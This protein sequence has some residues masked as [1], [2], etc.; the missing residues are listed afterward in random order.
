[1]SLLP[2]VTRLSFAALLT[3]APLQP[4]ALAAWVNDPDGH[5]NLTLP[6]AAGDAQLVVPK[7][8]RA[9]PCS[10]VIVSHGR[11]GLASAG[12]QHAP[13]DTL[14]DAIDTQGFV[15]LLSSDGGPS[16][17]GNTAALSSIQRSYKAALPHF[18][19]D[20]RVYTLGVSMSALPATLTA[21]RRTLGIPIKA[22]AL[23]AGRVNLQDAVRSS[24]SR[25]KSITAAYGS[26]PLI[27]SDPV[28]YFRH[29][30]GRRTPLIV[31]VSPQDT[32]VSSAKN[33]GRLAHLARSAGAS[34]EV[35][36]VSGQHLTHGYVNAEIGRQIGAFFLQHR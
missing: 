10:L 29:F 18:Q 35:V 3:F 32:V 26:A 2:S 20:G 23:V 1:M 6:D 5:R 28:N 7:A 34:V 22:V 16:T 33:G 13:F 27:T 19:H 15:L 8:C 9:K 4:G 14:L 30:V 21:Y 17:W 31:V 12:I 25:G 36:Q 11:G 24:V